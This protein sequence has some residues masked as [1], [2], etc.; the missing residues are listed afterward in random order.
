[1][2]EEI[3]TVVSSFAGPSPFELDFVVS[4]GILHRGQFVEMDYSEGKLIA[5]VTDLV[6]TNRYFERAES[7]KEFESNG[8]AMLEQFPV[9]GWEYLVAK[10][11]PLGVLKAGRTKRPTY[12]PSPGTRV[13]IAE[14]SVLKDFLGF[15]EKGL[16]LGEVEYHLLP[17]NLNLSRLLQKHLAILAMS[18]AGKSY[19]VSVLLE[20]LL[21][22]KKEQGRM[23]V[24]VLDAHG[25]YLSF[26][27]PVV[28]KQ[29][30]DY[31][32]K[33]RVLKA[34]DLRIGV[35]MIT[36][37]TIS[38]IFPNL[39]AIQ[40]RE[41]DAV[42]SKLRQDMRSGLGPFDFAAVKRELESQEV[43]KSTRGSLKNWVLE[44]EQMRLFD[45]VDSFS[46]QDLVKP[47]NLAII[48]LS[49][50]VSIKKKQIIVS[51]LANKLFN[52]RRRKSI[53]PF[54]LVIEEAHQFAPEGAKYESALAKHVVET[55]AREGRKFGASLCLV[56]QRPKRLST[57]ALSQCN[58]A[59]IMRITNP[60]DL[61]HIEESAEGIDKRSSD[62]LTSLRVGEAVL[63]GEATN[64][65]VFFKV[66]ER[67]SQPLRHAFSL[68]HE[69]LAFEEKKD[70]V[71]KELEEYL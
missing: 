65:P 5:M 20:E 62:M 3:G 2:A 36:A 48:D 55:I 64:Y 34:R 24:I 69:S 28:G 25:E 19:T 11:K 50:I 39:T 22:R 43:S 71:S 54:L 8:K 14:N 15:E 6:K 40:R 58:T 9:G 7:V 51:Y 33:T 30:S 41:L 17:V 56:S 60:Y 37:T 66:R 1:M 31:S 18:G 13:R 45:K 46:L 57:T 10:T 16:N 53:P 35:P 59:L 12:P 47:G 32:S 52:E 29:H 27:E 63:V 21:E 42:L 26:A 44:L 23:A 49:E 67:K 61:K 38:A 68:E 4:K 70:A